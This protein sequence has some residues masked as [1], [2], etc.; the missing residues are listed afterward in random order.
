MSSS[1]HGFLTSAHSKLAAVDEHARAEN[2]RWGEAPR[3]LRQWRGLRPGTCTHSMH[4]RPSHCSCIQLFSSWAVSCIVAD[5]LNFPHEE[6]SS[7]VQ[8]DLQQSLVRVLRSNSVA[9]RVSLLALTSKHIWAR[10]NQDTQLEHTSSFHPST[11]QNP[12]NKPTARLKSHLQVLWWR[13]GDCNVC[14]HPTPLKLAVFPVK[15]L[16]ASIRLI[17]RLFSTTIF[18][19]PIVFL[20]GNGEE[21]SIFGTIIDEVCKRATTQ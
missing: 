15:T 12:Y 9:W 5:A 20:H 14:L 16:A 6:S 17:W 21:H 7:Q 3:L 8:R 4:S 11:V 1:L 10:S 13:C 2:K 19:T 18:V